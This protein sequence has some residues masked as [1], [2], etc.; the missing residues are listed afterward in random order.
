MRL[1]LSALAASTCL[2]SAALAAEISVP[3]RIDSV[4]VFPA[5]A[6]ILRVAEFK[7]PP[8]EHTLVLEGLPGDLE[9]ESIRVVGEAATPVEIGSVD[10]KV[11]RL[12]LDAG[13]ETERRR[14]EREIERLEDERSRLD[15]T[16]VDTEMQRRLIE[17]LATQQ[18]I[19]RPDKDGPPAIIDAG[20][21]STLLDT[22][23]TRLAALADTV[24]QARAK[25]REIGRAIDDLN[26]RLEALA[27]REEYRT[28]AS[29]HVTSTAG[30]EGALKLSYRIARAS[31][32]PIYD[33]RLST[34]GD[35]PTLSLVRRAEVKQATSES[36]AGVQLTL[37]TARA[38]SATAAPDL[39][40]EAVRYHD[41]ERE[42]DAAE[43][44]PQMPAPGLQ[45]QEERKLG[46]DAQDATANYARKVAVEE[47]QAA[48]INAGFHALYRIGGRVDVDNSGT[49][50]KVQIGADTLS[51]ALKARTSP[52]LDPT[53][54]LSA[55]FKLEGESPLLP[56]AVQ[57]YRDGVYVG[58]GIL[59]LLSPGDTQKLGFGA[60]DRIKVERKEVRRTSGE[61]GIITT[62]AV[63]ERQYAITLHNL[64][65]KAMPV[66]V[67]DQ[68][69]YSTHEDIKVELI[70][71][72]TTPSER[73]VERQRGVMAWRLEL[74]PGEKSLVSF[75]Y[76]V[77]APKNFLVSL[78][79][80]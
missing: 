66:E 47:Q 37:S 48:V 60:D 29:I 57:L 62:A 64:H 34:E 49:A 73:D 38:T 40:A 10:S 5:G 75:G 16:I 50:K 11:T 27:P 4:T 3:S 39:V 76:R 25:Q 55:E 20:A 17:N 2:T 59:P 13:T 46:D 22:A 51:P 32:Q 65:D 35:K 24:S 8:G 41:R 44:M 6:E 7:I 80:N 45:S 61:T 52:K 23:G 28:T 67:F 77:T 36:W 15:Q 63:D 71:G 31:W 54:Y 58:R 1:L 18:I 14:L 12:G 79:D 53:V 69:P 74:K 56:G 42:Q 43:I 70:S 68:M 21:L 9:E 30:T 26:A 72:T 33:A 78:G 19:A